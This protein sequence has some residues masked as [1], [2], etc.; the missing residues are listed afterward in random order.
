MIRTYALGFA[1]TALLSMCGAESCAPTVVDEPVAETSP[2]VTAPPATAAPTTTPPPTIPTP[3]APVS[4]YWMGDSVSYWARLELADA[5]GADAT[6]NA[7]PGRGLVRG[8]EITHEN[9]TWV[10]GHRVLPII[11][12]GGW[13]VLQGSTNDWDYGLPATTDAMRSIVAALPDNVC[14]A[15]IPPLFNAAASWF[16]DRVERMRTYDEDWAPTLIDI[17]NDQPCHRIMWEWHDANV[18]NPALTDDG[19]HPTASGRIALA[20]IARTIL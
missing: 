20:D 11:R 2:P 10:T 15:Y 9:F 13:V 5:L 18:A 4:V 8:G 19:V 12:P 3:P 17:V 14:L 1:A 16:K 6:L 7:D